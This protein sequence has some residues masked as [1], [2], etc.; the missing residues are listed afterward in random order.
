MHILKTL[1]FCSFIFVLPL[2]L[3]AYSLVTK[4]VDGHKVRIFHVP[5]W[6]E[7]RVTA[8]ASN[9]STTLKTLIAKEKGIAWINGAYFIPKD[10]TGKPDATN[11][12]RIMNKE[13]KLYSKYYPDTG[14]NGIFGFLSDTSPMLVQ[15]NI[16]GEKTLRANYNSDRIE[17]IESGIANFPILLASGVNL[18]PTY[19]QA[20]LITE[21]MKVKWT[22]SFI[23]RT[24][25]NDIKMGTLGSISMMDVPLLIKKFGCIDAINLDNGGSLALYDNKKYV[26]G[27]GRNIMDAYVIVKK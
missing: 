27:P 22:K 4:T 19:D 14:V 2:S 6:G 17:D 21:K 7:Y 10:Y 5:A 16:Y 12:V 8:V 1:L 23:C 20:W 24:K 15:N 9:T 25:Q 13:G 3:S 11:T 18:V 26:V